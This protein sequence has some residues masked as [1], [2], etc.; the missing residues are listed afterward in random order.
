MSMAGALGGAATARF[1]RRNVGIRT[2][3]LEPPAK[4]WVLDYESIVVDHQLALERPRSIP[5]HRATVLALQCP[6]VCV[7]L[8]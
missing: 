5:H 4:V 6:Q 3:W 1:A 7:A 2:P 8:S